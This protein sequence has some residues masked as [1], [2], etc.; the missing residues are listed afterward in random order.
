MHYRRISHVIRSWVDGV[1]STRCFVSIYVEKPPKTCAPSYRCHPPPPSHPRPP[2]PVLL[3]SLR[4]LKHLRPPL[5]LNSIS[6]VWRR[7]APEITIVPLYSQSGQ[8][9]THVVIQ[10]VLDYK[11]SAKE[12]VPSMGDLRQNEDGT[13]AEEVFDVPD[14]SQAPRARANEGWM[15]MIMQKTCKDIE[16]ISQQGISSIDGGPPLQPSSPFRPR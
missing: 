6:T 1:V 10:R 16:G 3:R 7:Y 8:A 14:W 2:R 11:P 12:M 5:H 15:K 4:S 13:V 9:R